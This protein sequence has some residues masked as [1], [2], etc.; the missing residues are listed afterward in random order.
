MW[1][2]GTNLSLAS[3]V[4]P[5]AN[6]FYITVLG[7]SRGEEN[8]SFTLVDSFG[9]SINEIGIRL[10]GE[11]QVEVHTY[12]SPAKTKRYSLAERQLRLICHSE[13]KR[14]SRASKRRKT[15]HRKMGR[16][17]VWNIHVCHAETMRLRE[18]FE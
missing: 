9:W 3:R 4:V 15:I 8:F 12:G 17:N 18:G 1:H 10:I 13:L 6:L 5:L 16:A 11:K 2:K 7:A 14:R